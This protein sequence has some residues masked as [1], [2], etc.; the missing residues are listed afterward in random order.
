MPMLGKVGDAKFDGGTVSK[1]VIVQ[2]AGNWYDAGL[3]VYRTGEA[4]PRLEINRSG[5]INLGGGTGNPDCTLYRSAAN[6]FG[7]GNK[8]VFLAGFGVGNSAAGNT[9]GS[10]VKK[11]EVFDENGASIGF[12]PVYDAITQV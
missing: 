2:S 9:L 8:F 4:Y 10:L 1:A 6:I 11:V 12:L 7:S 5:Q 3:A